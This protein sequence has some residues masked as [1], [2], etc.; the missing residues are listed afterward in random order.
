M[1]IAEF[2][3]E[4]DP[5]DLALLRRSLTFPDAIAASDAMPPLWTNRAVPNL[6]EWPLPPEAATHP[7]TAGTFARALRLWREEGAALLEAVRR[8]TLLPA[9]VLAPAVPAMRA[10]GRLQVGADADLV[11]F[12]AARVTD[13]ATYVDSTRPSSGIAHVLVD[14]VFVVRSGVLVP[15]AFPGRPI[16][17]E[18]Q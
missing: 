15:D 11:V 3:D 8:A 16:R 1:V 6:G 4:S 17:A 5:H 13:Q 10:K 12:D 7:R 9:Q 2:L 14:G 18:P